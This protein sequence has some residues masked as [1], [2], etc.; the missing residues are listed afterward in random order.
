MLN[1]DNFERY[2]SDCNLAVAAAAVASAP[3]A[4]ASTKCCSSAAESA[5]AGF[6]GQVLLRRVAGGHQLC[7]E[8][9]AGGVGSEERWLAGGQAG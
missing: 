4:A 9:E 6:L 8:R 7:L 1:T 5:P 3:P 2:K